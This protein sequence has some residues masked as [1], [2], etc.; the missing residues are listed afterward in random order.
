MITRWWICKVTNTYRHHDGNEM[1]DRLA[2]EAAEEY[3]NSRHLDCA[4]SLGFSRSLKDKYWLQHQVEVP[5]ASGTSKM[6]GYLGDVHSGLKQTQGF[7]MN[8]TWAGQPQ[9]SDIY[10][11]WKALQPYRHC[12]HS[13]AFRNMKCFGEKKE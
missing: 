9:Q 2:N 13:D 7:M 4:V 8:T 6:E 11:C 3:A 5:S 1:A 10:Q 12:R